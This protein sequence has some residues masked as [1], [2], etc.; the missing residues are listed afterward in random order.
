[1]KRS[2]LRKTCLFCGEEYGLKKDDNGHWKSIHN[3]NRSSTCS[4][5]CKA[6]YVARGNYE[7]AEALKV[8]REAAAA[9]HEIFWGRF[10]FAPKVTL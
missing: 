8:K 1:M 9:Q 7:R 3:F 4:R 5:S 2:E 6:K 10:V